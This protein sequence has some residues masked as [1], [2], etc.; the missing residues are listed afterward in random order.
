MLLDDI[1]GEE[2]PE[3]TMCDESVNADRVL[4]MEISKGW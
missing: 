2:G 3:N 1:V 4:F